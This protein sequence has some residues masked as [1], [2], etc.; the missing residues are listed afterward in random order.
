MLWLFVSSEPRA[1]IMEFQQTVNRWECETLKTKLRNFNRKNIPMISRLNRLNT[2]TNDE[3]HTILNRKSFSISYG[4]HNMW[5]A[6][7]EIVP[8]WLHS[9][10][11]WLSVLWLSR[12]KRCVDCYYLCGTF[13]QHQNVHQI[14]WRPTEA[15]YPYTAIQQSA[16]IFFYYWMGNRKTIWILS[17]DWFCFRSIEI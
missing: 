12:F 4:W 6:K 7:D 16:V 17:I 8:N 15:F 1:K 13:T 10:S 5:Y 3:S 11:C 2:N 14:N 9:Y